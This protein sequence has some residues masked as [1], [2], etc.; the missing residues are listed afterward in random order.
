[1]RR[2]MPEASPMPR[3]RFRPACAKNCASC[4]LSIGDGRNGDVVDQA[5]CAE[6]GGC[7]HA[8]ALDR[9]DHWLECVRVAHCDIVDAEACGVQLETRCNDGIVATSAL[10]QIIGHFGDGLVE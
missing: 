6:M 9:S 4:G 5:C 1:M 10:R 7:Q 2:K 3:K 8:P